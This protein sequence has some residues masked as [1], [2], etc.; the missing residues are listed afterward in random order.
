MPIPKATAHFRKAILASQPGKSFRIP[1]TA[2][3]PV[4]IQ[5]RQSNPDLRSRRKTGR[6]RTG[7]NRGHPALSFEI[8][9][10]QLW[11]RFVL[12]TSSL[13]QVLS[14]WSLRLFYGNPS[15]GLRGSQLEN[16]LATE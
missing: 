14:G 1:E 6:R 10:T 11:I 5:D 13:G 9:D 8:G 12:G 16:S 2:L 3:L 15:C 7:E 4:L